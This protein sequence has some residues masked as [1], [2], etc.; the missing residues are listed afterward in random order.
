MTESIEIP[1][2]KSVIELEMALV[3]V[4][5]IYRPPSL[6]ISEIAPVEKISRSAMGRHGS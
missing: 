5:D 6:L 1:E 4:V 2:I 3:I